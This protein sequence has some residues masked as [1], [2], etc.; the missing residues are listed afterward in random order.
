MV[1]LYAKIFFFCASLCNFLNCRNFTLISVVCLYDIR[2]LNKTVKVLTWFRSYLNRKFSGLF[3]SILEVKKSDLRK[4]NVT[5]CY[6]RCLS[7]RSKRSKWEAS[8]KFRWNSKTIQ[9]LIRFFSRSL[10]FFLVRTLYT[11]QSLGIDGYENSRTRTKSMF[12]TSIERFKEKM[13]EYSTG[14]ECFL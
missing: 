6:K 9:S 11:Q 5:K 8:V 14:M 10:V 1:K 4:Q 7:S 13:T 2:P 3:E 12:I